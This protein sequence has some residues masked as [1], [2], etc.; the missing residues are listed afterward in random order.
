MKK[1][2]CT[3]DRKVK[4]GLGI[5]TAIFTVLAFLGLASEGMD[6]GTSFLLVLMGFDAYY[7]IKK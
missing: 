1:N 4:V 6:F 3:L 2:K 7:L 5:A